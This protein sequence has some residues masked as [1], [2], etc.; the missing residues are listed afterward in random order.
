[1]DIPFVGTAPPPDLRQ[2]RLIFDSLQQIV[3][4]PHRSRDSDKSNRGTNVFT[5]GAGYSGQLGRKFARGHKKYSAD[6]LPIDLNEVSRAGLAVRQVACGQEHTALVTEG[7]NIY[8]WGDGRNGELGH[9]Y[10][11]AARQVPQLVP[12]PDTAFFIQVACGRDHTVAVCDNGMVYS[13][14]FGKY[15]QLGHGDRGSHDSPTLI[16]HED[17]TDII[18]AA[19]GN[20]HTVLLSK[21]GAVVSFGSGEHGQTGHGD[22][23]ERLSPARVKALAP[24]T[25]TSIACGP[26]HTCAVTSQGDV[27]LCGFGENFMANENQNFWYTPKKVPYLPPVKQ[28][29]C[30]QAHNLALTVTGSVYA[31]GCSEYGQVGSGLTT[32][33]SKV[34][35]VVLE[36]ND[37]A[38]VA[39]GRYHSM[40][41]TNTG[42]LWTWGCGENG[43]LGHGN[44]EHVTVPKLVQSILGAVVGH[45]ACGEHHTAAVTSAPWTKYSSDV[46]NIQ[47]AAKREYTL[48]VAES[49]GH[50]L[51]KEHRRRVREEMIKWEHETGIERERAEQA[52]EES[53]QR[54]ANSVPYMGSLQSKVEERIA[55][56]NEMTSQLDG[57]VL[58]SPPGAE[59]KMLA[60]RV[61]AAS[62]ATGLS[63]G[64]AGVGGMNT[65]RSVAGGGHQ[66]SSYVGLDVSQSG[67]A[68]VGS[69]T[70]LA[71]ADKTGGVILED[72][73]ADVRRELDSMMA[74]H[75][76][77]R[78]PGAQSSGAG[79]AGGMGGGAGAGG[80]ASGG[81]GN[82]LLSSASSSSFG[83]ST[84]PTAYAFANPYIQLPASSSAAAAATSGAAGASAASPGLMQSQSSLASQ[85]P[86]SARGMAGGA[87]AGNAGAVGGVV[88]GGA[89]GGQFVKSYST[90]DLVLPPISR[91][92]QQQQQHTHRG[93]PSSLPSDGAAA[94]GSSSSASTALTLSQ[95]IPSAGETSGDG[96][97]DQYSGA[98]GYSGSGYPSGAATARA[99]TTAAM[100]EPMPGIGSTHDARLAFFRS[101]ANMVKEMTQTV[102]FKGEDAQ[103]KQMR[104][105]VRE[106]FDAR[107]EYDE[108]RIEA[109][110]KALMLNTLKREASLMEQQE[111][112]SKALTETSNQQLNNLEMRLNTVTIQIA[113]TA[114]NKANYV[115]NI[116][117]LK[118]EEFDYF[119]QLKLLRRTVQETGTFLRKASEVRDQAVDDKERV[120]QELSEFKADVKAY[121]QFITEQLNQFNEILDVV[122][123]HNNKRE[124][125]RNA[126]IAVQRKKQAE[127]IERLSH[128]AQ[129]TEHDS[130]AL[131]EQLTALDLKLKHFEDTFAKVAS[132]TGLTDTTAIVNKFFFKSE[133]KEQLQRDIQTR[134]ARL[135]ALRIQEADLK[136]QLANVVAS[137]KDRTWRDVD[138]VK[139]LCRESEHRSMKAVADY[140]AA[141]QRL[142]Y[143]QEGLLALCKT[144]AG[145]VMSHPRMDQQDG[146]NPNAVGHEGGAG[147][148]VGTGAA[149][150][151]RGGALVESSVDGDVD[152]LIETER[153]ELWSAQTTERLLERL[154][155]DIDAL[156]EAEKEYIARQ[157][158][159]SS[160]ESRRSKWTFG[161]GGLGFTA[162]A[163]AIASARG[164]RSSRIDNSSSGTN[165]S[166]HGGTHG[167]M[168]HLSHDDGFDGN[169]TMTSSSS[170]STSA[171]S[172]AAEESNTGATAIA[173]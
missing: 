97:G 25:V 154:H 45:I 9:A 89:R 78:L 168:M 108:L 65:S 38:Q 99:G 98:A 96:S 116:N 69:A 112:G 132:A 28:V 18:M 148:G 66:A 169:T 120:D 2:R 160:Q 141:S 48:K 95:T 56:L 46:N 19:C 109:H 152:A 55:A 27:Y 103:L 22:A 14:G 71:L 153:S 122:R 79:A 59:S 139:E 64:G 76:A 44:D 104:R 30:G 135:E 62:S 172:T 50:G 131:S 8:T 157:Q 29:A 33:A 43:Q 93:L 85:G 35:R 82:V 123:A 80:P 3:N 77:L 156:L 21:S 165:R 86:G 144:V 117:H 143:V 105:L 158:V 41:L 70:A 39:A 72:L 167:E 84:Q 58:V 31:W 111:S 100:Y 7:G 92:Q 11:D 4:I 15:G 115:T 83:Q 12:R 145:A 138:K 26:V 67:S 6:P 164:S 171:S 162:P 125:A 88:G 51:N 63:A 61:F 10:K 136:A 118:E 13:W 147:A 60:D 94:S 90:A 49:H 74:L 151:G 150:A 23:E 107:R 102:Q 42:M 75:P 166:S 1:M 5:W 137:H 106:L 101:A 54:A 24:H 155:L 87:G 20:K 114:E 47:T 57:M 146:N 126:Q 140:E 53:L 127:R 149:S 68:G 161:L 36:R 16:K 173:V 170:S 128:E 34:P 134:K 159:E 37:V 119:N 113:E 32:G 142:A 40:A 163:I 81:Q 121:Q 124:R 17:V 52:T 91:K 73:S 130:K 133:I 129:R 110:N